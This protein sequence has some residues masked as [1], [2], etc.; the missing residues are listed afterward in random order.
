MRNDVNT[1]A[2]SGSRPQ[3]KA[4]ISPKIA[5]LVSGTPY[6]AINDLQSLFNCGDSYLR[7]LLSRL[8]KRHVI[9]R[10]KRGL[11]CAKEYIDELEKNEHPLYLEF[12]ANVIYQPSYLSLDYVLGKHNVLTE[13]VVNFTSITRKKTAYFSNEFG[14]F[15]YHKIKDELFC[16][17]V[18][19]RKGNFWVYEASKA[20]AFFDFLYLRKNLISDEKSISE[21]RINVEV[22]DKKDK[23][24]FEKYCK[25]ER[26]S[27]LKEAGYYLF[28]A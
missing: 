23:I 28:H 7:I 24:E 8:E 5:A 2:Y 18:P 14:N 9:L 1:D 19:V 15:F 12:I 20:K 25:I 17:F 6:F 11:Y 3:P 10:L 16:G 13:A 4:E 27:K 21:L 22:F 26:S